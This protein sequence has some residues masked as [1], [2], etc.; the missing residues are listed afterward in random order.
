LPEDVKVLLFESVRELLFNAV[1]HAHA[2][3]V[4]VSLRRTEGEGIEIEVSDSGPGFDPAALRAGWVGGGFGL[5]SIRERLSLVGG[6]VEIDS[7]PGRG[8]RVRLIAPLARCSPA[9]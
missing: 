1:K 2:L 7:T 5:F 9:S 8:S 6:R 3:T 4:G